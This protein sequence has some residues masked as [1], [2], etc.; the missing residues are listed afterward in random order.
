MHIQNCVKRIVENFFKIIWHNR[1]GKKVQHEIDLYGVFFR[2]VWYQDMFDTIYTVFF[3]C[4][5]H[6]ARL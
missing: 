6:F 2:R 3:D 5:Q 4:W 1:G